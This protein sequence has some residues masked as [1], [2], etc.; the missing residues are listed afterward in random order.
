[1]ANN[2]KQVPSGVIAVQ[3]PNN[4]EEYIPFLLKVRD[5]EIVWTP[6]DNIIESTIAYIPY[7]GTADHILCIHLNS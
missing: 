6:N 3:D 5:K 1:M 2:T 7:N 4:A